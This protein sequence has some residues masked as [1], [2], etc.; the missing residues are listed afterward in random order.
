MSDLTGLK[1]GVRL[2]NLILP[3]YFPSHEVL[4]YDIL[5]DHALECEKLGYHS[6]WINDHL[7]FGSSILECW[8]T[9][10]A[11]SSV[12]DR[13]RLGALVLCN[14]FRHP[15]VLAKMGATL[16]YISKG[17]LEFGIGAGW[18]EVEHRAYGLSFPGPAGRIG[19]LR[20][21][22]EITKRMWTEESP[23]YQG[24]YYRIEGA[25][26]E[27]KPIQK[28]H[29]PITIG[30]A[31]EEL[32]MRVVAQHADMC[33]FSHRSP[34]DYDQKLQVLREHCARVGRNYDEIEKSWWG[35]VHVSKHQDEL[36]DQLK[37]LYQS[38]RKDIPFDEWLS[39]VKSNSII[40]TPEECVEKLHQY[41][42]VG[43]TFFILR[44]GDVPL[45]NGL[46]LFA[47]EVIPQL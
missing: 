12:T 43:I 9:L 26:C 18:N 45:K 17:R 29:P 15:S 3:R 2:P 24:R 4:D 31:G 35:R 23:S 30:G 13:V 40:G 16:D 38:R 20:E 10:S 19:R 47:E 22:V 46:R 37:V 7:V 25:M 28:P 32:T 21:A 34:S 39:E 33:N 14:G 11:L 42:D 36:G 44:F 5:V 41:A 1:F 8:T 27:P 6:V